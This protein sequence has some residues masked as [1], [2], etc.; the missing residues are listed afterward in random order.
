MLST[1]FEAAA[2]A[3][4]MSKAKPDRHQDGLVNAQAEP[5]FRS[6]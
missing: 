4:R 3:F 6:K 5:A 1:A 2:P